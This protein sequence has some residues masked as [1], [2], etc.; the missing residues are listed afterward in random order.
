MIKDKVICIGEALI[1]RIISQ[2]DNKFINYFGGAPANVA[3]ALSKLEIPSIFIGRFGNDEFGMDF[4]KLLNKNKVNTNFLQID[5]EHPTRI[6]E[7]LVDKDG[8]RSFSGFV[9]GNTKNY[10]DEMLSKNNI[11]NL[12]PSLEQLFQETKYRYS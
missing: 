7:V 12:M 11:M 9:N 6:I 10:A 4:I 2:P 1:D 3:C 8:D 5:N